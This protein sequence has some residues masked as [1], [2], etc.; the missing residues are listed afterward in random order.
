MKRSYILDL[1][2]YK[3]K[4]IIFVG[5]CALT[6]YNQKGVLFKKGYRG[7]TNY[8][9]SRKIDMAIDMITS[10]SIKPLRMVFSMG[11]LITLISVVYIVYLIINKVIHN[12]VYDGW[13]TLMI[14][15]WLITGLIMSSLGILGIYLSKIFLEVKDRPRSIV[16]NFFEDNK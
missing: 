5:L 15:I 6:G 2:R 3:E 10:F 14:S 4:E 16:K 8:N 11:L 1:I 7:E 12:Y 9:L 13:T